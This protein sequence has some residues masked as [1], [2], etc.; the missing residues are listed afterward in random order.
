[1]D[2]DVGFGIC[3]SFVVHIL[4]DQFRFGKCLIKVNFFK[5]VSEVAFDA[6]EFF[7]PVFF[8][9]FI[10]GFDLGFLLEVFEINFVVAGYFVEFLSDHNFN[11]SLSF[12]G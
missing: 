3:D 9:L 4:L 8:E 2:C 5:V 10:Q 6:S 1:M 12:K 7:R 11:H